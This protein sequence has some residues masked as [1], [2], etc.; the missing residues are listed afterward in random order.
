MRF[1]LTSNPEQIAK[2][3]KEALDNILYCGEMARWYRTPEATAMMAVVIDEQEDIV[4]AACQLKQ[5][6]SW[7]GFQ[8]NF[9]VYVQ[10]TY[11]GQGFGTRLFQLMERKAQEPLLVDR[12]SAFLRRFQPCPTASEALPSS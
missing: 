12:G 2:W 5:P 4:G 11:R 9:G 3:S 10:Q 1:H 7:I 6:I 8:V